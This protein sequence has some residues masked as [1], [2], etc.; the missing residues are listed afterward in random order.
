MYYILPTVRAVKNVQQRLV[1]VANQYA[2]E[3]LSQL[4]RL[5]SFPS[6]EWPVRLRRR[7]A[8]FNTHLSNVRLNKLPGRLQVAHWCS[9]EELL[10]FL[11]G[12]LPQPVDSKRYPEARLPLS[13]LT[14]PDERLPHYARGRRPH[15]PNPESSDSVE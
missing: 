9:E 5:S 13:R 1:K 7:A 12:S 2:E 15:R 4:D 3:R 8:V 11:N 6:C 14:A 10:Q